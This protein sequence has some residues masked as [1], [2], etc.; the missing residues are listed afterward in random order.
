[1][2]FNVTQ[3]LL[4]PIIIS[5]AVCEATR[6]IPESK[7]NPV[8]SNKVNKFGKKSLGTTGLKR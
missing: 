3:K 4:E 7:L 5:D 1:M 8:Y 2:L 6:Q